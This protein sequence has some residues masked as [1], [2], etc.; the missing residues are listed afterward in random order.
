MLAQVY[1][2][3]L[4]IL[5]YPTQLEKYSC[6]YLPSLAPRHLS[7]KL[8]EDKTDLS[9]NEKFGFENG[10]TL[11]SLLNRAVATAILQEKSLK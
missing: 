1:P 6:V 3:H 5:Q 11:K 4:G 7:L 10:G 2:V 8:C 9:P